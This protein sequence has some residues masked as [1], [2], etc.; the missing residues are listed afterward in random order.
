MRRTYDPQAPARDQHSDDI[1]RDADVGGLEDAPVEHEDGVFG[2]ADRQGVE[3]LADEEIDEES[4]EPSHP[5]GKDVCPYAS[6]DPEHH[7]DIGAC[8]H[9]LSRSNQKPNSI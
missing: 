2:E 9:S 1:D 7:V 4:R 8:C 3:D 6:P 5:E